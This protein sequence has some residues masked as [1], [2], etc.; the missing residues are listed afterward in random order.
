MIIYGD[1]RQT[2]NHGPVGMGDEAIE[3]GGRRHAGRETTSNNLEREKICEFLTQCP[4][5]LEICFL[6]T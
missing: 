3:R 1:M 2:W 4:T 6:K 5:V